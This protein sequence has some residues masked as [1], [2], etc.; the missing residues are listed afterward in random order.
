MPN[1]LTYS[2]TF[3]NDLISPNFLNNIKL[4]DLLNFESFMTVLQ[5]EQKY[6]GIFFNCYNFCVGQ[7]MQYNKY[8]FR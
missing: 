6:V 4:I 3:K 8:Q 1:R 2:T 7:K 5:H